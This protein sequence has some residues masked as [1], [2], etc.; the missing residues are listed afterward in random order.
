MFI[1]LFP[2][3]SQF[4]NVDVLL[5]GTTKLPKDQQLNYTDKRVGIPVVSLVHSWDNLT[6][7]GLLSAIPDRLLV[8]N[9]VMASEA[10]AFHGIPGRCQ[11]ATKKDD[12]SVQHV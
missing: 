6:S 1:Y 9:E 10:E 2:I 12:P 5:T 3:Q 7:K 4:K 8:W 11:G